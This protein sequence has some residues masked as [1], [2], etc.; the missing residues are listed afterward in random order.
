MTDWLKTNYDT[1]IKYSYSGTYY[2]LEKI[3]HRLDGPAVDYGKNGGLS[4]YYFAGMKTTKHFLEA[5]LTL[6]KRILALEEQQVNKITIYETFMD[7]LKNAIDDT[8]T[9]EVVVSR[10]VINAITECVKQ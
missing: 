1:K 6:N 2:Y 7:T 5:I 4:E 3:P 9:D 8:G 10:K